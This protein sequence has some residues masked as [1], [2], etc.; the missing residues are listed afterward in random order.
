MRNDIAKKTLLAYGIIDI[1][2]GIAHTWLV[3][4]SSEK[5]AGMKS[6]SGDTKLM[7]VSFGCSNFQTGLT[8]IILNRMI[9]K[10]IAPYILLCILPSYFI[11]ILGKNSPWNNI[12]TT[13]NFPGRYLV[14]TI[15]ITSFIIGLYNIFLL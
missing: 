13:G 1:I 8:L 3:D 9:K 15:C 12:E 2:R 5:I 10:E 7:M 6:P 11:G 4:F 14:Y